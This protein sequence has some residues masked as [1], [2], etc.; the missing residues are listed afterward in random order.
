[1]WQQLLNVHADTWLICYLVDG[2][3]LILPVSGF[4]LVVFFLFVAFIFF[5]F[6][7]FRQWNFDVN[8]RYIYSWTKKRYFECTSHDLWPFIFTFLFRDFFFHSCSHVSRSRFYFILFFVWLSIFYSLH[9]M[10][11]ESMVYFS[12]SNWMGVIQN[13]VWAKKPEQKSNQ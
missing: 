5:R 4:R 6:P 3:Q 10:L 9:R 12:N 13:K 11:E 8:D 1:M 7:H 2:E